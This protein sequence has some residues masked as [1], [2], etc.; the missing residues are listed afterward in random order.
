MANVAVSGQFL[1]VVCSQIQAPTTRVYLSLSGTKQQQQQQQ[2]Q[3][4]QKCAHVDIS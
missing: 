3:Q 1:L 4:K 2:Q